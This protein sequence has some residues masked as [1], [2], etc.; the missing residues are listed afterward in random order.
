[1]AGRLGAPPS[2]RS[3]SEALADVALGRVMRPLP[4]RPLLMWQSFSQPTSRFWKAATPI[5]NQARTIR[6]AYPNA[7]PTKAI[8]SA[9]C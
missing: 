3:F 2:K 6:D 9:A 4:M 5:S 8:W 7:R 1:M